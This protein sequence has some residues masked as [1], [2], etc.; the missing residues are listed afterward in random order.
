ML[1]ALVQYARRKGLD[2]EAGFTRKTVRW[3]VVFNAK[4]RFLNVLDLTDPNTRGSKGRTFAKAPH[5]KFSGD[6]P[7]RQFLIDTAEY[8]LLYE[9]DKSDKKLRA[10]HEYFLRLLN[11][12]GEADRR[13]RML[14]NALSDTET[15]EK[16]CADLAS[17]SKPA[18]PSENVTFAVIDEGEP[19]ILVED[20]GWHE[21]WRG[22]FPTLFKSDDEPAEPTPCLLT[23]EL[24]EPARTHPKIKGLGGVGGKVETTL[25]GFNQDA[26]CSYGLEQSRNAAV[27]KEPAEQYAAALNDL[28][29]HRSVTLAGTKVIYWFIGRKHEVSPEED[30]VQLL[31][32][33]A[34]V[35]S[36]RDDDEQHGS[37]T[38]RRGETQALHL[39]RDLLEAIRTG[40]RADLATLRFNAMT[41]SGNSARVVVRDW[42]EG[43]FEQLAR[44]VDQWFSDLRIVARGG[45]G[46]A[47]D[48]KFLAVLAATVRDLDELTPPAVNAL[49]HAA[50]TGTPIPADIAARALARA[51]LDVT[52]GQTPRHAQYGLLRAY[53]GRKEIHVSE[54]LDSLAHPAYLSG[55]VMALVARI[56]RTALP[57]VDAGVVE[58]C[59]AA[60]SICPALHLG[61]LVR[62]SEIAHIPTIRK[63]RPGLAHWFQQQLAG[64]WQQMR[65]APPKTLTLE[66]QTLFAMGYY[67]QLAARGGSA[68][69]NSM[70]A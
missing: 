60:T 33:G 6:T 7:M 63:D 17:H 31:L 46:T 28:I 35:T 13:F 48:P 57:N 47:P 8:A 43:S 29:E 37:T 70:S 2:A 15:R 32:R 10:K 54:K 68:D 24:L 30:P 62:L 36:S 49:W 12:A 41:M 65:A 4:G 51:R 53:L 38:D 25:I 58:R 61:R 3:L 27:G 11:E 1:H 50:L 67:H 39:A 59:Y 14:F 44:T 18:K 16:V 64:V 56:Q 5:L 45:D 66:E 23:G 26:F 20:D 40:Q 19:Q 21:W 69:D 52:T 42:M 55:R 34:G 9:A 22:Y